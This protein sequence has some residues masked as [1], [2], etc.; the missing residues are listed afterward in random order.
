MCAHFRGGNAP[1]AANFKLPDLRPGKR[2]AIG[3]HEPA[4]AGPSAPLK[5]PSVLKIQVNRSK[6]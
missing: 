6:Q 4:T 2:C 5:V 3:S 1:T